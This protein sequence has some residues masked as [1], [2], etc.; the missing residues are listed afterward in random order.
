MFKIIY[1]QDLNGKTC[2]E[3]YPRN[4]SLWA[5]ANNHPSSKVLKEIDWRI[6]IIH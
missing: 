4:T 2:V 5:I 1:N 6:P 3:I